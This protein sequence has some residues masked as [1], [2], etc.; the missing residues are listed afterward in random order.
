MGKRGGNV[1]IAES[2]SVFRA[3]RQLQAAALT[4]TLAFLNAKPQL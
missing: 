1:N 3:D 4:G 2:N